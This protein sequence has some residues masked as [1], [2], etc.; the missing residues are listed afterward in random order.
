[1]ISVEELKSIMNKEG[2]NCFDVS[3]PKS[4]FENSLMLLEKNDIDELLKFMKANSIS[5]VFY[6]H[7]YYD[8]NFFIIDE[9]LT[10]EF[11]EDI[12]LL[13]EK[14]IEEYNQQI[15]K[16]DFSKPVE[17]HIFCIYEGRNIAIN[18][19]DFWIDKL[20]ILNSE[21][22]MLSLIEKKG[23]QIEEMSKENKLNDKLLK[24]EFKEYVLN[25]EEFKLCTNKKLRSDY[26]YLVFEREET[27]RYKSV[28]FENDEMLNIGIARNFIEMLWREYKLQK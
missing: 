5:N 20:G 7:S 17:I 4:S 22:K 3:I 19:Y 25:D 28:F 18:D 9:E 12:Y 13:L 14:D 2:I 24:E 1:M 8:E 10:D 26:M 21:E 16:L 11:D 6:T 15:K 27:Q 23:E